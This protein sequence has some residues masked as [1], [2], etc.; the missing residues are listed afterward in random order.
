MTQNQLKYW[1]LQETMRTNRAN[2]GIK[3][4]TVEETKRANLAKEAENVR[5]HKASEALEKRDLDIKEV[6]SRTQNAT[7]VIRTITGG[8]KDLNPFK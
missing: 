2:E 3:S 7:D 4:D 6:R 1:E 5:A 8:V